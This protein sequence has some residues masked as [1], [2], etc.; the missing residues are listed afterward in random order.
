METDSDLDETMLSQIDFDDLEVLDEVGEGDSILQLIKE[1]EDVEKASEGESSKNQKESLDVRTETEKAKG[2][3]EKVEEE[4]ERTV[5]FTDDRKVVKNKEGE[6]KSKEEVEL[7]EKLQACKRKRMDDYEEE[8][9]IAKELFRVQEKGKEAAR[10]EK[11]Q[12]QKE[13]EERKKKFQPEEKARIAYQ[14]VLLMH[15]QSEHLVIVANEVRAAASVASTAAF[16]YLEKV[17]QH[18][19]NLSKNAT[20]LKKEWSYR[21]AERVRLENSEK[22]QASKIANEKKNPE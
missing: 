15:Q 12:K 4:W 21:Q 16:N 7:F 1:K 6:E 17:T 18:E 10:A 19:K 22:N 8:I 3:V 11:L 5:R 2:S 20:Y 9:K 14:E 13:E